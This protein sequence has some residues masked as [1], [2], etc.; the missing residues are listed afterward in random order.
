MVL[1]IS[2]GVPGAPGAV[3]SS[4]VITVKGILAT[5]RSPFESRVTKVI[6]YNLSV[7]KPDIVA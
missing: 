6:V 2:V 1:D 5:E 3:T 7:F 4:E